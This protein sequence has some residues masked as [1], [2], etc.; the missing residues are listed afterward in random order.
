MISNIIHDLFIQIRNNS[1]FMIFEAV[2]I[3]AFFL[4]K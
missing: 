1:S 2:I 3:W 4:S